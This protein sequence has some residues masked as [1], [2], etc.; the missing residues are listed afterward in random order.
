MMLIIFGT[1][2]VDFMICFYNNTPAR[3]FYFS[4]YVTYEAAS[5][6]RSNQ[7]FRKL[8]NYSPFRIRK[9]PP[10][11]SVLS[12]VHLV[13][14]LYSISVR[15]TN[16]VAPESE[17]SSPHSQQPANGPYPEPRESTPHPPTN[18]PKVHFNTILPSMPW[19][20]T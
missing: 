16:S 15:L 3:L 2:I 14:T 17:G 11:I 10:P 8:R 18:L 13:R 7:S 9:V 6:L 5:I 1:I 20:F 19:S 4:T 12:H